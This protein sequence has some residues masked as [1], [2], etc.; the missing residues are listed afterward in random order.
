MKVDGDAFRRAREDIKKNAPSGK[1]TKLM[2]AIGTQRWL[3][4][5]AKVRTRHC[6]K[7]CGD[8]CRNKYQGA[9]ELKSLDVRTIQLL[10]EGE[11]SPQ[12]ISAVSP[13]LKINGFEYAYNF[14]HEQ[15]AVNIPNVLDFR[16]QKGRNQFPDAFLKSN[17]MLSLD[18]IS[19]T[20]KEGDLHSLTVTKMLTTLTLGT[21]SIEFQWLYEVSIIEERDDNRWLGNDAET[22]P[23][24]LVS[25]ERWSKSI[26]FNQTGFPSTS[27]GDFLKVISD[28]TEKLMTIELTVHCEYVEKKEKIGV[29]VSQLKSFLDYAEN[30]LQI[31]PARLQ[32][33]VLPLK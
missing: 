3:A 18:P 11:A 7:T 27:W 15:I 2:P 20:F 8:K 24:S 26:M 31:I 28:T 17:M 29:A 6:K 19:L 14:G 30:T 13:H 21:I 9:C 32:P 4:N 5:V 23:F 25:P 33:D 22:S 12:T 10:E 1:G 16:S